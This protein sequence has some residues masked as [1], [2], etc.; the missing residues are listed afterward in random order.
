[1]KRKAIF[2]DRDGTIIEE[3]NYLSDPEQ[4]RL[5]PGS[6]EAIRALSEAGFFIVMVTNQ[7]GVARGMFT[8]DDVK[9]VNQRVCTELK[10]YGAVI[11]AIYYC[12]HHVKGTV[13]QYAVSCNCRKPLAGMGLQAARDHDLDLAESYMIGDKQADVDFGRNCG[14]K[15]AY[16][17]RTGHGAEQDEKQEYA[18][19]VADIGQA[20][21]Q[22]LGGTV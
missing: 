21:I 3:C 12:P 18:K 13:P 22:I 4:V 10:R 2:L 6:G 11:D 16:L 15:G 19:I 9:K 7:S 8:E 1:M 20:A 5:I 17:V 14:M